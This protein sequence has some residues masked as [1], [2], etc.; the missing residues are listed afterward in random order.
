MNKFFWG[1]IGFWEGTSWLI[2]SVLEK[3]MKWRFPSLRS[4]SALIYVTC[5]FKNFHTKLMFAR[6]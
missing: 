3:G 2:G 5:S 1:N 6:V 4:L